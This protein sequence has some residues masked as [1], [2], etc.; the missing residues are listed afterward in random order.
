MYDIVIKNGLVLDGTGEASFVGDIGIKSAAISKIGKIG[1][2]A[3]KII[4]AKGMVVCPG[5]IDIHTHSDFTILLKYI[6]GK[7]K[8]ATVITHKDRSNR[9][10][11][12]SAN[13]VIFIEDIRNDVELKE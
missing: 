8:K 5:F 2:E 1:R 4:N 12:K 13:R 6:K 3:K 9:Q 11:L 10:L 7:H